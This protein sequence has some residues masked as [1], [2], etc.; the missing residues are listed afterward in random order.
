MAQGN[1][2]SPQ[3]N[4]RVFLPVLMY[5]LTWISTTWVGSFIQ[6]ACSF[7][8]SGFCALMT[9]LTCHEMGHFL[10]ARRYGVSSSLPWLFRFRFPVQPSVR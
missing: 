8:D 3:G 1:T 5:C 9:I 10:Q 6:R 4:R 7:R 2:I